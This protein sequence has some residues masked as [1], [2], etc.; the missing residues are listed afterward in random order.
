MHKAFYRALEL[1]EAMLKAFIC[2]SQFL[3][4]TEEIGIFNSS[5]ATPVQCI[6]EYSKFEMT[7]N[8]KIKEQDMS[9][10]LSMPILSERRIQQSRLH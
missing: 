5:R 6:A 7:V 1:R 9:P 2:G 10:A 4:L 3:R 8:K